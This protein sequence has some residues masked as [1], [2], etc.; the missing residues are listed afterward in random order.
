MT[1][2]RDELINMINT[3][4]GFNPYDSLSLDSFYNFLSCS[5]SGAM[6]WR[7]VDSLVLLDNVKS[8]FPHY[9]PLKMVRGYHTTMCTDPLVAPF[10]YPHWLAAHHMWPQKDEFAL[11]F[12]EHLFAQFHLHCVVD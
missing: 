3:I 2:I 11:Y 1:S 9:I 4:Q 12:Y 5:V 6:R 7:E 8:I 10:I